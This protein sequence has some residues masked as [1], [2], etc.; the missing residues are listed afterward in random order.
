MKI[1]IINLFGMEL[2]A[3][4]HPQFDLIAFLTRNLIFYCVQ[5]C[6][7]QCNRCFRMIW[8]DFIM[9]ASNFA[10]KRLALRNIMNTKWFW[11]WVCHFRYESVY[12]FGLF[13]PRWIK[14]FRSKQM[15]IICWEDVNQEVEFVSWRVTHS[16]YTE[17]FTQ[18]RYTNKHGF[19][20]W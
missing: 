4:F 18:N 10:S 8:N 15:F 1:L 16:E 17:F 9:F 7:S 5:L 19:Y 11:L 12:A 3:I 13:I 6:V 20:I 14:C 2:A